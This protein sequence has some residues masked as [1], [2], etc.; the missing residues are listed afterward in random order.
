MIDPFTLSMVLIVALA[1]MG[2]SIGIS[3]L[4][5]SFVYLLAKGLDPSIAAETMLQGLFNGYTLLAVPLFILAADIMN[6]GSL[7]D[8]L[9]RFAQA[10]VGRFKGGRLPTPLT[11][12]LGRLAQ[13]AHPIEGKNPLAIH[14]GHPI[15]CRRPVGAET[16]GFGHDNPPLRRRL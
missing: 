1:V 15:E 9:L 2:Q 5:G 11:T 3:M 14:G 6:I 12:L 4:A 10:L 16:P 13:V 8:R 7:A